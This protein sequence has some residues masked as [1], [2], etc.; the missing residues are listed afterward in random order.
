VINADE[1][2][3]VRA[4]F[5]LYDDLGCL[6]AVMRRANHVGL[7]SKRHS[8]RS[9]RV[10]GG[11]PFS[12][13][14]IYA[15]LRNPIYIGKI[16]H[17]TRV[18]DGQ[19][20][21]ILD[22]DLWGRV[23]SKLQAASARPR[24]RKGAGD[25]PGKSRVA[26][27]TGKL[28]DDTGD[29]LTP[30]HTQRHGRQIR[31]YVSNR[32]ISGGTDPHGW[33]LPAQALE[34]AVVDVIRRHLV[35]FARDHR[36]CAEADLQQS[37]AVKDKLRHLAGQLAD[38]APDRIAALLADGTIGRN[39]ITLRLQAKA[40]GEALG[41]QPDAIDPAAVTIDAPFALR[42]RGVEG[43]IIVGDREPQSDRTMLRALAQAHAWV[44]DLRKGRPL[45]D[46]AAST[47][48]SESYIRTRAQLA[49][50]A[51]AIQGAIL[52]GTSAGRPDA[53]TDHPETG[54]PRLGHPGEALRVWARRTASLIC[55]RRSLFL[56]KTS[57]IISEM[58]PVI[59]R[60]EFCPQASDKA[61]GFT[62]EFWGERLYSAKFPCKFPVSREIRAQPKRVMLPPETAR[63]NRGD[64]GTGWSS[65]PQ[66]A[67]AKSPEN[68]GK[69]GKKRLRWQRQGWLAEAVGFEPTMR[70]PARQFSRLEPSTT[71]PRFPDGV[72]RKDL[73]PGLI[74][75]P[76][77][78]IYFDVTASTKRT[79]VE[80]PAFHK[81][82][83]FHQIFGSGQN[84]LYIF[85]KTTFYRD[86]NLR[87]RWDRC[88][89]SCRHLCDQGT[90][91]LC[92]SEANFRH[93]R[94][95]PASP[96][97]HAYDHVRNMRAVTIHSAAQAGDF[98]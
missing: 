25:H 82:N 32:L 10:Q 52:D 89:C 41:L 86:A 4:I 46:I 79:Q 18:W 19:H 72:L 78:L 62:V 71:R 6:N 54:A 63:G 70:F 34:K 44:A 13:G 51:P 85:R 53:R 61:R 90:S 29:R 2:E 8:F 91:G 37:E 64:T 26:L 28:R 38:G 65:P 20:A 56:R 3:T 77:P 73:R 95:R 5:A 75:P 57:L 74:P 16:R 58:F 42:R 49:Y 59:L 81:R 43:K 48:H 7:R 9:G 39:R 30:T 97:S 23:Q 14:Q 22:E 35:A 96:R 84:S 92:P 31:Y 98:R 80:R 88:A 93:L 87:H 24:G 40:L 21:P 94:D 12:R 50:L 76:V 47:G 11:T 33:R 15:L 60:R 83:V 68:Q 66:K 45:G 67:L 36:I 55:G 17:K 69:T 1:A 27:L